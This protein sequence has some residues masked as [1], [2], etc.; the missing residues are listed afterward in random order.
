VL[1]GINLK[2]SQRNLEPRV[3]GAEIQLLLKVFI[4]LMGSFFFVINVESEGEE[5]RKQ[6][7][8]SADQDQ[9]HG[10]AKK[11]R[12]VLPISSPRRNEEHFYSPFVFLQ[13]N[14]LKWNVH[15]DAAQILQEIGPRPLKIVC[16]AGPMRRGKS[17]LMNRLANKQSGFDVGSTVRGCTRGIWSWF[18]RGDS[19]YLVESG[20]VAGP[21]TRRTISCCWTPRECMIRTEEI[22]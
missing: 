22:L 10:Q 1:L 2:L 3:Q 8:Q 6:E 9:P 15:P 13:I 19:D 21:V 4:F 7:S 12:T 20:M 17:Y 16:I 11:S 5:E 18:I 14:D